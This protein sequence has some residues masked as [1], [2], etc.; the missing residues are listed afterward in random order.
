MDPLAMLVSII[1]LCI[2]LLEPREMLFDLSSV[3]WN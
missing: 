3:I 2:G 1:V